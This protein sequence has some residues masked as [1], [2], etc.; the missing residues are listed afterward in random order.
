[1]LKS[2]NSEVSEQNGYKIEVYNKNKTIMVPLNKVDIIK[3]YFSEQFSK[4]VD[5]IDQDIQKNPKV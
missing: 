2:L 4:F 3:D 5:G 1:M